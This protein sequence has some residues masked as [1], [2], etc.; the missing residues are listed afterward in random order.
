MCEFM[1]GKDFEGK[2]FFDYAKES[3]NKPV[4]EMVCEL[5]EGKKLS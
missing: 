3:G 2:T 1:R 4:M 5:G